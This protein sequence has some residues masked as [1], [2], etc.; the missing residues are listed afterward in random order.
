MSRRVLTSIPIYLNIRVSTYN[1]NWTWALVRSMEAW[2]ATAQLVEVPNLQATTNHCRVF[3][4]ALECVALRDTSSTQANG[5]S[6]SDPQL[7]LSTQ[8]ERCIAD[9]RSDAWSLNGH[10]ILL[11]SLLPT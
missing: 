6:H 8:V 3:V 10:L 5:N 4:L 7:L 11:A 2:S 9:A 1:T